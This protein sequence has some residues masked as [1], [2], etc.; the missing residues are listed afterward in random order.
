MKKTKQ[1]RINKLIYLLISLCLL[2]CKENTTTTF[3]FTYGKYG[4]II[5]PVC[6]A[7]T[8][9]NFAFDTGASLSSIDIRNK[10]SKLKLTDSCVEVSMLLNIMKK[11]KVKIAE[12]IN[13]KFNK[14]V[15]ANN[16][17]FTVYDTIIENIDTVNLIGMNVIKQFFW[18]FDFANKTV[19][20]SKSPL[21]IPK[22][23]HTLSY[24]L[25]PYDSN[26]NMSKINDSIYILNF[27]TG[28]TLNHEDSTK[29]IVADTNVIIVYI[30]KKYENIKAFANG[31]KRNDLTKYYNSY[32]IYF[33]SIKINKNW[34]KDKII[35]T[36][37][38]PVLPD[39][40]DKKLIFTLNFFK[41]FEQMYIDTK[42]QIIYLKPY[43]N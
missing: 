10:P 20:I 18:H 32:Q 38:I 7:D 34:Y 35:A 42:E 17:T 2:S 37:E 14:T 1:Y 43:E 30:A 4:H 28:Y 26:I 40:Y 12:N 33:D 13:I 19:T 8:V 39:F 36:Y 22:Y 31:L 29:N 16:V 15:L 5:I 6:I 23:S 9:I 25:S 21:A 24:S 41:Q 3:P 27:D 11:D